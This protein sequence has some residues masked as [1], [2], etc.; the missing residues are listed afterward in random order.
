MHYIN[1]IDLSMINSHSLT[2]LTMNES[3]SCI[4]LLNLLP[5]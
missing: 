5:Y 1:M 2:G 4:D 3:Q